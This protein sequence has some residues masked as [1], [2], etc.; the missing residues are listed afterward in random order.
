MKT[1][2]KSLSYLQ[3]ILRSVRSVNPPPAGTNIKNPAALTA[4]TSSRSLEDVTTAPIIFLLDALKDSR[5][6]SAS[7]DLMA[8]ID[9]LSCSITSILIMT[10]I[11]YTKLSV[12]RIYRGT[13]ALIFV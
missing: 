5:F 13:F 8:S 4:A 10:P 11:Y 6:G 3:R 9:L 2:Y 7:G 1:V 12:Q